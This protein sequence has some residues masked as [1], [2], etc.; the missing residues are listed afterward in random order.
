MA[1]VQIERD[2]EN[3]E[4]LVEAVFSALH[5]NPNGPVL[6]RSMEARAES[7]L[8]AGSRVRFSSVVNNECFVLVY[9]AGYSWR[10]N[11][12]ITHD[13]GSFCIWDVVSI[14]RSDD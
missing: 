12:E 2:T 1:M 3:V 13:F 9:W 5:M 4:T 11:A 8:S 10:I 14:W 6:V 7:R